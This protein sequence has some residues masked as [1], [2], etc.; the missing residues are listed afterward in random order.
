MMKDTFNRIKAFA[1]RIQAKKQ[2]KIRQEFL[3]EALEIVEKPVSPTGHLLLIISTAIVLFFIIWSILGQM[4]EVVTARGI[5]I[6]VNGVQ[7][8]QAP[9]SGIIEEICVQE[10][11]DVK[12]GDVIARMDSSINEIALQGTT[13]EL[14]L[15]EY[16]NT[17]L[18]ELAQGKDIRQ[19][20]VDKEDEKKRKIYQYVKSLQEN[21]QAQKEELDSSVRQALSQVQI[22]EEA[23]AKLQENYDYLQMQKDALAS[24]MQYSNPSVQMRQKVE[25]EMEQ[26]KNLLA[27]YQKLYEAGA[28]A[29]IEVEKLE[30]ELKQLQKEYEIQNSSA[31][32][33]DNKNVLQQY[34]TDTQLILAKKDCA[35]Q[36]NAVEQAQARHQQA[37]DSRN[38]LETKFQSDISG[39]LVQNMNTIN[40]QKSNQKIQ[41]K[42]VEE[43][44]LVS[45]VDGVVKTLEI[46]TVG[47]V[48][49]ST[50]TIA[51]VVPK[52]SQMILE[53]DIQN[54]DI[55]YI[56]TN[57]EVVIKLDTFDFQEYGKLKGVVV[58]ISP[59]A[60]WSDIYGWVYK[61]K[62][63]IDEEDFKQKNPDTEIVI[64]MECTA[65]VK[66][67]SRR[68][69][70]FFLEPLTE[71]FDGSLKVR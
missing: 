5:I 70:E 41:R 44:T 16:E 62:I 38:T 60:V 33:A 14:I 29:K 43:Q 27:D 56:Q 11:S 17:L 32:L 10:G 68:I 28:V 22:E 61:A 67:G 26:T 4:D 50:Q 63:A 6:T 34:E 52:D 31:I 66:I 49:A 45:P 36:K 54:R 19:N 20:S 8:I 1:K 13:E 46:H 18:N 65:E 2:A 3:P 25:L 58:F 53:A 39:I 23:L 37:L 12:A 64:G 69:I 55:G 40:T 57:Q 48:V 42:G 30:A 21:Y 47:G 51:T 15:L 59:D 71:H 7:D 35:S 24:V 9:G